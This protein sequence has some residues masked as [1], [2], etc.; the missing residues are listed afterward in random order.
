MKWKRALIVINPVA[1]DGRSLSVLPEL[2]KVLSES[3]YLCTTVTTTGR[4]SATSYVKKLG[5]GCD[6][7]ICSGGDGTANEVISGLMAIAEERRPKFAYIP[8]GSTN[9]FAAALGIPKKQKDIISMIANGKSFPVDVGRFNERYYAY[10]CAFGAFTNV[11]HETSQTAKNIFGPIA[12]LAKGIES[13][14]N[15]V[16]I[17]A[18]FIINGEEIVDDFGFCAISNSH[19][20]GGV[21][22]LNH[23]LVEMNDGIFEIILIKYPEDAIGF[24]KV[25]AAIASG[26]M[27]CEYIRIFHAS[28]V[29]VTILGDK[30]VDFTLDGEQEKNIRHAHIVNI[31]SGIRVV[32]DEKLLN[33]N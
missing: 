12:Y 25:A 19:V 9:D 21:I 27:K 16:P 2:V 14:R 28:E 6:M 17:K 22:R 26:E 24:S 31:R 33:G 11:S 13:L 23:D 3:E 30:P 5:T 18:R 32:T 15:I 29:D 4:G 20:L 1:G 8:S 7:V 10:V